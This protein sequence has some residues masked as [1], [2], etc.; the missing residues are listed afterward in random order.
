MDK[1]SFS[2]L[3][4]FGEMFHPLYANRNSIAYK[5]LKLARDKESGQCVAF[6]IPHMY[7]L[8]FF[9]MTHVVYG[10]LQH[11]LPRSFLAS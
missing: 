4:N 6:R 1:K 2:N 3:F 8:V 7:Y 5:G 10:V 9:K 11:K